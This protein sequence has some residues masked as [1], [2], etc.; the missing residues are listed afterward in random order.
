MPNNVLKRLIF[1]ST[2]NTWISL[3]L[4]E[5]YKIK[6]LIAPAVTKWVTHLSNEQ[7]DQCL[8]CYLL[9]FASSGTQDSAFL[10]Y[11]LLL[12]LSPI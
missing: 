1:F 4:E 10:Q 11:Q 7:A 8:T 5:H 9:I 3:F 6:L 12:S 2:K